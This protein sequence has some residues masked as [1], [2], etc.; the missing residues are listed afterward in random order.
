MAYYLEDG[1]HYWEGDPRPGAHN[2]IK[3]PQRPSLDYTWDGE[4]WIIAPERQIEMKYEAAE[5][6]LLR[7][8]VKA[9]RSTT[10]PADSWRAIDAQ[11]RE[12]LT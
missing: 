5:R 11:L 6:I 4:Q 1:W 3:V 12:L 9:I 7:I 2:V 8:I 10:G